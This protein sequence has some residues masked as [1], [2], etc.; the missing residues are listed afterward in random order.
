M[1]ATFHIRSEEVADYA[2][3]AETHAR[4]FSRDGA[5]GE[6]PMVAVHRHRRSFDPDLAL[7]AEL[8]GQVV[9]HVLFTP[10]V[11]H[12]GGES[13]HAV[14]LSPISVHPEHQNK[15]IGSGLIEEGLKRAKEK[16][17]VFSFLLGH[18]TYYPRFGYR[19]GMFGICRINIALSDIDR[20]SSCTPDNVCERPV[21]ASDIPLLREM[22]SHWYGSVDLAI[23]PTDS[24]IDWV[25]IARNVRASVM[26]QDETVIGY[27]RYQT[28]N[29][30]D[31]QLFLSKDEEATSTIL[32][33]LRS[34]V[35]A[36]LASDNPL[37]LSLQVHPDSSGAKNNITV[38][39]QVEMNRWD[40]C[41][42]RILADNPSIEAYC[43]GVDAELRPHGL[44]VWPGE[45]TLC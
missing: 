31:I 29:P 45:F 12:V 26:T 41:M 4:A 23:E 44:V 40:S 35:K 30:A 16:G 21:Q 42:I 19:K 15:G 10:H 24:I 13:M 3:I 27:V 22:W 17:Y 14:L 20:I 32:C 11:V 9:G 1:A 43:D 37:V 38:P 5:I 8:G 33:Y 6:V 36:A 7:V 34:R 25:S 39:F 2:Y 28:E 18:K